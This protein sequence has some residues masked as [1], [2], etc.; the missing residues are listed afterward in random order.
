MVRRAP[1]PDD[2]IAATDTGSRRSNA[3]RIYSNY[4]LHFV[5]LVRILRLQ[6]RIN[7]LPH[8]VVDLEAAPRSFG[9]LAIADKDAHNPIAVV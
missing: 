6:S 8:G 9:P 2:V 7:D 4:L 3:A 5:I 1:H